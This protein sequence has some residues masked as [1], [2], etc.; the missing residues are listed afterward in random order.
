[1]HSQLFPV[2]LAPNFVFLWGARALSAPP[3]YAYN[4]TRS[5]LQR[6]GR[7]IAGSF[8]FEPELHK[9]FQQ[10]DQKVVHCRFT[11]HVGGN[12]CECIYH[13]RRDMSTNR[14]ISTC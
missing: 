5:Y 10:S 3:G 4:N 8:A 1:V 14:Q 12:V 7:L 13:R 2:N 6:A 9:D 11:L